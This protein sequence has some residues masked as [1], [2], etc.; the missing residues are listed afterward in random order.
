MKQNRNAHIFVIK[1]FVC[2]TEASVFTVPLVT[3][4]SQI[5]ECLHLQKKEHRYKII[6]M[7]IKADKLGQAK[8]C[9]LN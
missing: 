2:V 7:H 6:F 4:K 5:F 1:N 8:I 9:K 3:S